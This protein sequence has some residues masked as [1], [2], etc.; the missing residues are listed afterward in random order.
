MNVARILPE[1]HQLLRHFDRRQNEINQ[2]ALYCGFRHPFEF[3]ISRC[4]RERDAA[5]LLDSADAYGAVG[6]GARHDDRNGSFLVDVGES[7]KKN[8]DGDVFAHWPVEFADAQKSIVHQQMTVGCDD[9]NVLFL[10]ADFVGDFDHRHLR[11][12]LEELVS[13]TF[14]L[15]GQMQNDD[16]GHAVRCRH[17]FKK[18]GDGGK[19]ACRCAY[20]DERI[21]YVT[22]RRILVIP[23]HGRRVGASFHLRSSLFF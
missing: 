13:S 16:E 20:T 22:E 4:L 12:P 18:P 6:T 1:I 14:V 17:V 15:G 5:L 3:G 19:S 2:A 9:V 7:P 23:W 10:N 21:I 11:D 8:I